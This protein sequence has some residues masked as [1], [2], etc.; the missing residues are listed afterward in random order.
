MIVDISLNDAYIHL[1]RGFLEIKLPSEKVKRT[2]ITDIE[3]LVV[4]GNGISYSHNLVQRLCNENIPLIVCGKNYQPCGMLLN[5]NGNFEQ[6]NR[7]EQQIKISIPLKKR[8]WQQIIR[9]KITNQAKNL[10]AVEENFKDILALAAKVKSGDTDNHEAIAARKYW[11][12]LFG[13]NFKRDFEQPGI[14]ALLNFGYA[15]LRSTLCRY[16]VASGLSP[17][18]GVHHH[19]K[20]NP[21]CLADDLIEPYRPIIDIAVKKIVKDGEVNLN[22]QSKRM[23]YSVL[24]YVYELPESQSPLKFCMKNTVLS[25]LMSITKKKNMIE[26]PMY[27][28]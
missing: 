12:R 4:S 2:P 15:I 19:N 28:T 18:L 26:Y 23:L 6:K 11:K 17:A 1:Y 16:I 14:N 22:P 20:L 8:L 5:L 7:L 13:K 9:E 27:E 3:C 10:S 21:W 25:F 24:E